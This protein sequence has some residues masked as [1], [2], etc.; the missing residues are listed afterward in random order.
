MPGRNTAY[1]EAVMGK[2]NRFYDSERPMKRDKLPEVLSKE[3]VQNVLKET[4]K[5]LQCDDVRHL[6]N[7]LAH[8]TFESTTFGICFNDY[9]KFETVASPEFLNSLTTWIMLINFQCSNVIDYKS[10]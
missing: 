10:D 6:R 3:E 1:Y 9:D 7:A 4:K 2:P 5:L 8:S